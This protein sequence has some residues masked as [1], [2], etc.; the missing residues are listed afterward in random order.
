MLF[1]LN[2]EKAE[3]PFSR[4]IRSCDKIVKA[5]SYSLKYLSLQKHISTRNRRFLIA[6]I[7]EPKVLQKEFSTLYILFINKIVDNHLT[8]ID[9]AIFNGLRLMETLNLSQNKLASIPSSAFNQLQSLKAL[10]LSQNKLSSIG[11][12]AF[13]VLSELKSLN[14]SNNKVV[15]I[16]RDTFKNLSMFTSINLEYNDFEPPLDPAL[17]EGLSQLIEIK[18]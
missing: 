6:F 7:F 11:P 14:L 2:L 9:S 3:I 10:N 13:N 16:H 17:F 8:H 18:V 1:F 5:N 15:S 12:F 4:E